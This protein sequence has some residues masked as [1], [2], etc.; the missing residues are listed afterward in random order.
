MI[1]VDTSVLIDYFK[2]ILNE[3]TEKFQYIQDNNLEFG[4]SNLI[5]L[6]LLQGAR[7]NNEYEILKEYLEGQIFYDL[8]NKRK[9]YEEAAKIY[10]NCRKKGIT[11][12]S[13]IDLIICQTSIENDLYLL[14]NDK[15]FEEILK[16]YK[17]L[18]IY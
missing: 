8:K 17:N 7:D 3:G 10:M 9:S 13:T 4:I 2:G 6:E 11:I 18:R 12:R 16:I 15:D 1:L 14:H 5:Y